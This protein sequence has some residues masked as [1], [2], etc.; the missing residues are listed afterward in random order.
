MFIVTLNIESSALRMKLSLSSALVLALAAESTVAS[1]WFGT[2]AGESDAQLFSSS[3]I[4]RSFSKT[5]TAR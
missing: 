1:S 2:K 3:D 4:I 5:L